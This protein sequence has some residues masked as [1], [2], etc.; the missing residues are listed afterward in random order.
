MTSLFVPAGNFSMAIPILG[1]GLTRCLSLLGDIA[2]HLLRQIPLAAA[3]FVV[4]RDQSAVIALG[5]ELDVLAS[6]EATAGLG[7]KPQA[8]PIAIKLSLLLTIL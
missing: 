8:E 7:V 3:Y 4:I 6:G 1:L 5:A 2:L